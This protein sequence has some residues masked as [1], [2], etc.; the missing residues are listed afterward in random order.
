[1]RPLRHR[2]SNPGYSPGNRV[3]L[4][5]DRTRYWSMEPRKLRIAAV[6]MVSKNGNAELILERATNLVEAAAQ[7][8]AKL[9]VLPELFSAG[10]W[11]SEKAWDSAEPQ[12]WTYGKM[13]LQYRRTPRTSSRGKLPACQGRRL[14]QC[15]RIGD[16]CRANCRSGTPSKNRGQSRPIFFA[17]RKACISSSQNSGASV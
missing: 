11:L 9:V 8:G 4:E 14:L 10:Y 1:M 2:A 15:F 6:Q 17:V 13:A 12:G 5:Q 3:S 16:A 7:A